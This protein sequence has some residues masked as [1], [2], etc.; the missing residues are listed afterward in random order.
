MTS[1]A[2]TANETRQRFFEA[3]LEMLGET[4]YGSLKQADLC[5]RLSLTTGA[6]YHAFRNW[7]AFTEAFLEYWQEQRIEAI[8]AIV[9]NE[10]EPTAQLDE[11][12]AA[13]MGLSH[14]AESSIRVWAGIDPKAAQAQAAVDAHRIALVGQALE[15]YVGDPQLAHLLAV[16]SQYALVGYELAGH[17]RDRSTLE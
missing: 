13:A 5:Q 6:F 1:V 16:S 10:L 3:A 9:S 17:D 2:K 11:I 8:T 7:D 4:G 12:F 15:R 14:L